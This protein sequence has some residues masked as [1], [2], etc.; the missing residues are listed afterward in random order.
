MKEVVKEILERVK[1]LANLENELVSK[2]TKELQ[3]CLSK[4]DKL[5]LEAYYDERDKELVVEIRVKFSSR[6][7]SWFN[8][9]TEVQNKIKDIITEIKGK[10]YEIHLDP[11]YK[12]LSMMITKR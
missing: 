1:E 8:R 9:L 3:N 7:T 12:E 11:Y 5:K 10:I 4:K 6:G 2:L